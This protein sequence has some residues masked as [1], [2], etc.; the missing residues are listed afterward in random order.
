MTTTVHCNN[1]AP[2]GVVLALNPLGTKGVSGGGYAPFVTGEDG[3][4]PVEQGSDALPLVV[5]INGPAVAGPNNL[6]PTATV[7]TV[8]SGADATNFAT[9]LAANPASPLLA[10]HG[11]ALS[12]S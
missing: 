12:H 11:G 1:K 2:N 4:G 8:L 6:D 7:D 3:S 10:S 9:W 5:R